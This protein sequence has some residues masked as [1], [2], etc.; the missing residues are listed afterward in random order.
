MITKEEIKDYI[1]DNWDTTFDDIVKKFG[2]K[3]DEYPKVESFLEELVK[4]GWITK[5]FCVEHKTYE[6]DPV[7]DRDEERTDL[8]DEDFVEIGG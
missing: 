4:E 6:Y 7:L 5:S 3:K 1:L 2:V 8:K